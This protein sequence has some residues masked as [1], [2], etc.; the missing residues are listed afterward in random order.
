MLALFEEDEVATEG[1]RRVWEKGCCCI[2]GET[3]TGGAVEAGFVGYAFCGYCAGGCEYGAG[4]ALPGTGFLWGG[5]FMTAAIADVRPKVP[6]GK[7]EA[8][9]A[10]RGFVSS[11]RKAED[12]W[13]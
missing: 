10:C 7:R 1:E 9:D 12:E 6:M 11:G 8:A 2:G 5:I 4:G 3:R 13:V